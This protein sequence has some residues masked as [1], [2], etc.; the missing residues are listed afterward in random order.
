VD[1]VETKIT[2]FKTSG[3]DFNEIMDISEADVFVERKK[4]SIFKQM[5]AFKKIAVS[6]DY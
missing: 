5:D 2:R 6:M 1:A 4:M 3:E